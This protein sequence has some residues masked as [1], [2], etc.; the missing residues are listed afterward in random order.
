MR[1]T[2]MADGA[3]DN[4]VGSATNSSSAVFFTVFLLFI[5]EISGLYI[6]GIDEMLY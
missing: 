4:P 2:E 6:N 1:M 5:P 3:A